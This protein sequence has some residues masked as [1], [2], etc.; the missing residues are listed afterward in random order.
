MLKF[1]REDA[2]PVM[3][4]LFDVL[5]K[6]LD[7]LQTSSAVVQ[8][9]YTK[10]LRTTEV[11][12]LLVGYLTIKAEEYEELYRNVCDILKC[13]VDVSSYQSRKYLASDIF[14]GIFYQKIGR[15]FGITYVLSALLNVESTI[16]P[17]TK[18]FL[19]SKSLSKERI[20]DA[21][22]DFL[23]NFCFVNC[24]PAILRQSLNFCIIPIS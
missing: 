5:G 8:K 24:H 23:S 19:L 21:A 3:D 2:N 1:I 14:L 7:I 11:I 20:N 17:I 18:R 22:I 6:L 4:E 15:G 16:H 13:Y 12:D 9:T 10:M